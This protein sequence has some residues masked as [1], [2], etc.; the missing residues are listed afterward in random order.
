MKINF[1]I[2]VIII[3]I[4]ISCSSDNNSSENPNNPPG[5]N[6][7]IIFENSS[8]T[9]TGLVKFTDNST[10]EG[11]FNNGKMEIPNSRSNK[12]IA[13]IQPQNQ[14][15]I[16]IGRKEGESIKLNYNNGILLHRAPI[17]G[18]IPIGTFAEF[19]LLNSNDFTLASSYFL[20]ADLDFMNVPWIPIGIGTIAGSSVYKT[21]KGNFYGQNH[22]ISNLNIYSENQDVGLFGA[23][24]GIADQT[25]ME[26]TIRSGNVVGSGN[27]WSRV[28]GIVGTFQDNPTNTNASIYRCKNY[29]S[30]QSTGEA[31]GIAGGAYSGS[32]TECENYGLI[33]GEIIGGIASTAVGV[34]DCLNYGK[35]EIGDYQNAGGPS[36]SG[37]G[38][39]SYAN[40]IRGCKN[41]GEIISTTQSSSIGG[42]ASTVRTLI[43]GCSNSG[44]IIRNG[45]ISGVNAQLSVG[46]IVGNFGSGF[47][48]SPGV[49]ACFNTGNLSGDCAL[50]GI[51]GKVSQGVIKACY[52]T[53]DVT[54]NLTTYSG[55]GGI[56]GIIDESASS[57]IITECYNIGNVNGVI[58]SDGRIRNGGILGQAINSSGSVFD[59]FWFDNSSDNTFFGIGNIRNG[60]NN[61]DNIDTGTSKFGPIFWPSWLVGDLSQNQF[62]KTLGSWNNGNPNYPK[63]Y[64][65]D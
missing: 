27:I 8:F 47:T 20:E 59:C 23:C 18:V 10:Y 28:G 4:S 43:I 51:A 7:L 42:I 15:Y 50:G 12:T 44:N 49:V 13:S 5:E 38:I 33:K 57:V 46:G 48:I 52:N 37:G 3:T 29:A 60:T 25:I 39:A 2:S 55:T 9:G 1:I 22:E 24:Q 40:E 34:F 53:G 65:E 61:I 54:S 45:I 26:L 21:F 14:Q 11:D 19:Q 64:F 32:V 6:T 58:N 63:L 36:I 16:L 30:I 31:G 56:V 41:S 62:W 35:I 17:S